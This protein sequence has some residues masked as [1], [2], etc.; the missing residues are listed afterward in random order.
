MD[1]LEEMY[2]YLEKNQPPKMNQEEIEIMNSL[3][4]NIEL[5]T[6]IKKSPLK[7]K[8]R[9]SLLHR[10]ILSNIQRRASAYFSETLPKKLQRKEH[11]QT[12]STRPQSLKPKPGKDNMKK[13]NYRPLSLMNIDAKI[14]SKILANRIQQHIKKDHTS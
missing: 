11:F 14:L 10:G 8:P 1:N 2:R 3:I 13:E 12:H 6:V 4:T 7:Q 9:A 5:E